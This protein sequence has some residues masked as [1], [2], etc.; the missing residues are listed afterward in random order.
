[1]TNDLNFS[2]LKHLM[3]ALSADDPDL[4]EGGVIVIPEPIWSEA[5]EEDQ[6]AFAELAE[7]HGFQYRIERRWQRR[8]PDR[9]I[10]RMSVEREE[11]E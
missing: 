11:D 1:M 9:G 5:S 10:T 7:S 3:Q 8:T 6:A 2:Q 4:G